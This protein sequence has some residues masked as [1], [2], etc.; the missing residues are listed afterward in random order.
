M[1]RS[2]F[3]F[4]TQL[5]V[6]LGELIENVFAFGPVAP[7]KKQSQSERG[8]NRDPERQGGLLLGVAHRRG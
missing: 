1:V 8:H 6:G 5:L 2:R 4:G 7:K 3:A